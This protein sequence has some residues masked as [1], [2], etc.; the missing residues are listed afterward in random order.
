[1]QDKYVI[2]N[3]INLFKKNTNNNY[4][5]YNGKKEI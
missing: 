1:M 3:F 2:K 4:K 5:E